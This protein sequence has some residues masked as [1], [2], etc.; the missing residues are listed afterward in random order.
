MRRY[1]KALSVS[2]IVIWRA[3]ADLVQY[4]KPLGG[5]FWLS[6][7]ACLRCCSHDKKANNFL[8]SLRR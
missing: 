5:W 4:Q 7:M 8:E 3:A 6:R 1:R 2:S